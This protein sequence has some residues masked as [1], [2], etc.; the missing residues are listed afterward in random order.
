MQLGSGANR[1][2]VFKGAGIRRV[3]VCVVWGVS[4]WGWTRELARILK[5]NTS[6]SESLANLDLR[7]F[8]INSS[9]AGCLLCYVRRGAAV[10]VAFLCWEFAIYIAITINIKS[11]HLL[12]RR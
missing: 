2:V 11:D 5:R 9:A 6:Q 4:F 8:S 7:S 10:S 3:C 12:I 1:P